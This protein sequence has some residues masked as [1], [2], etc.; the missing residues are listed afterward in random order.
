MLP[1]PFLAHDTSVGRDDRHSFQ[2][3]DEDLMLRLRLQDSEALD[4]L[5][6]RYARLI[7][8]IALRTLRDHGE[9]EDI[10]QETFLFL[11]RKAALCTPSHLSAGWGAG[12]GV[13][14]PA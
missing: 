2:P 5:F 13:R 7:M 4:A 11:Y 6:H 9:A 12:R 1:L 14:L 8:S 10:V 3:S